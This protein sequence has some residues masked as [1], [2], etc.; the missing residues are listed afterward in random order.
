MAAR[1]L[2]VAFILGFFFLIYSWMTEMPERYVKDAESVRA[3]ITTAKQSINT[4]KKAMQ[5][6]K[7]GSDW[8]FYKPYAKRLDWDGNAHIAEHNIAEAGKR[9]ESH[10]KPILDRDHEDDVGKLTQE[11]SKIR[12]MIGVA[13]KA[14]RKSNA[15]AR[16]LM[17]GKQN[18]DKYFSD[19][20]SWVK[21]SERDQNSFT[22]AVAAY[23]TKFEGKAKELDSTETMLVAQVTALTGVYA[24]MSTQYNSETTD[25]LVYNKA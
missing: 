17:T 25:F 21:T 9:F 11:L 15:D 1:L 23:K 8:S 3:S 7:D 6:L 2:Q 16:T 20:G 5:E 18:K 24:V 12:T 14:S 10:V 13:K 19:A 4:N 22:N